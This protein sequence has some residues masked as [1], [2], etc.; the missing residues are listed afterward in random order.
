MWQRGEGVFCVGQILQ[1]KGVLN[2]LLSEAIQGLVSAAKDRG[3][4]C[5]AVDVFLNDAWQ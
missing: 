3:L 2:V 5:W 1:E 4:G